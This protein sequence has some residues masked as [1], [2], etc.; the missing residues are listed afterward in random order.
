MIQL[1]P[2]PML[3]ASKYFI[4]SRVFT[5]M[6]PFAL[7]CFAD[8]VRSGSVSNRKWNFSHGI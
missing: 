4:A 1:M 3:C 6:H 2:S 5:S 7:L 8:A